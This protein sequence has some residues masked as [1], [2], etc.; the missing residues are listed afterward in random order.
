VIGDF[1]K[2]YAQAM[3]LPGVNIGEQAIVAAKSMVNK[4]VEPNMMV[5]GTPARVIRERNTGG[6]VKE[7]LAHIW[8]HNAAFQDE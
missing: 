6:R 5:A 3:I 2:I 8:F 1:A 4:D 7:G